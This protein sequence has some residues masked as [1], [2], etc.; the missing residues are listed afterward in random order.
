MMQAANTPESAE[1]TAKALS[2]L[3]DEEGV[4]EE[5]V[6]IIEERE[7]VKVPVEEFTEPS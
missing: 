6:R 7:T 3:T 1:S 4:Q 5:G 2:P